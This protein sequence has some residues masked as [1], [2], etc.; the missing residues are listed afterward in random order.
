MLKAKLKYFMAKHKP[1]GML[2]DVNAVVCFKFRLN[3]KF[4]RN[5][6]YSS[7]TANFR[8]GL[9]KKYI[10]LQLKFRNN[11][12]CQEKRTAHC[13]TVPSL[14]LDL[15]KPTGHVMHQQFNLL[16]PSGYFTYHLV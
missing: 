9:A 16:K 7:I 15:L 12:S 10:N 8:T 1:A 3:L 2:L 6:K 14:L 13:S 5:K 4:G 11:K